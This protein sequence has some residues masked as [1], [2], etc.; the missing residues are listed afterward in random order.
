MSVNGNSPPQP[1]DHERPAGALRGR[2]VRYGGLGV[3][4]GGAAVEIA[5]RHGGY[6]ILVIYVLGAMTV[7]PVLP[8]ARPA[9][10][11]VRSATA[12]CSSGASRWPPRSAAAPLSAGSPE[13]LSAWSP[14]PPGAGSW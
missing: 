13:P 7:A 2:L 8:H 9:R 1:T 6:W 11:P 12:W 3:V 4:L 14:D 10:W 5:A